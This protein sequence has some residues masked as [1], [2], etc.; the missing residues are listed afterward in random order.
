MLPGWVQWVKGSGSYRRRLQLWLRFRFNPW[1]G[2]LHVPWVPPQ[3]KTNQ[4]NKTEFGLGVVNDGGTR[5]VY[6]GFWPE[7]PVPGDK[8]VLPPDAGRVPFI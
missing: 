3:N 7:C 4:P 8:G 5:I 2:N 6:T 1:T